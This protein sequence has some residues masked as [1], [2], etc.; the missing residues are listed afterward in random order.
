M[1][2]VL[3]ILSLFVLLNLISCGPSHS[4]PWDLDKSLTIILDEALPYEASLYREAFIHTL[5]Q[6]KGSY[7]EGAEQKIEITYSSSCTCLDGN[8]AACVDRYPG[9]LIK[10]C[11]GIKNL[12]YKGEPPKYV[13]YDVVQHELGH[14][15]GVKGHA[16]CSE[17]RIMSP[18]YDCKSRN[19]HL[20]LKEQDI[21]DICTNGSTVGG[22]C[23][24]YQ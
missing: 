6:L 8:S 4:G 23:K 12:V 1:A 9:T 10:V 14:V 2:L 13:I 24:L 17:G 22:I 19:D 7:I 21:K 15:F 3:R 20:Y 11:Y 5:T 16:K 18:S